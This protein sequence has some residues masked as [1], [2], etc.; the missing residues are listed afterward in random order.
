MG[1]SRQTGKLSSDGM[2]FPSV[3]GGKVGI[4]TTVP[5]E[6]LH[7]QG[8]MR[9]TG[10][11][12]DYY[13]ASGTAGQI[14][15]STGSGVSWTSDGST[16]EGVGAPGYW[17]SNTVGL[18]TNSHVPGSRIHKQRTLSDFKVQRCEFGVRSFI[19]GSGATSGS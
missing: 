3:T 8:S 12:V 19:A 11:L 17:E 14:L 9:L 2:L 5:T 15:V 18:S 1:K 7:I 10:S 4:G 13:D 6:T 16:I